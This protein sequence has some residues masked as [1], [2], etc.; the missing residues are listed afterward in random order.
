VERWRV[1]FSPFP[2]VSIAEGDILSTARGALVS[3]ANSQGHMDG[4]I[5]VA[6]LNFF[7]ERLQ[8]AVYDA[9]ARRPEG[10]LPVGAA[11][12]VRTGHDLIPYLIVAPTMEFPGHVPAEHCNRA[13]R[14]VL[15]VCDRADSYVDEVYCPG[16]ATGIGSVSPEDAAHAMAD[17][18]REWRRKNAG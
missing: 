11:E 14:A 16:L 6:Y 2:E 17:A 15:R 1:E 18:Y 10:Y 13:M 8:S 3:P 7:G 4:G 5:D 9:I 12:I